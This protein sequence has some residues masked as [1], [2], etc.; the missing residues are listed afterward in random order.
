MS[1]VTRRSAGASLRL[2]PDWSMPSRLVLRAT[3]L[4]MQN[5]GCIFIFRV[6]R[7]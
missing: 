6:V 1:T 4:L 7:V 3:T 5:I 2:L